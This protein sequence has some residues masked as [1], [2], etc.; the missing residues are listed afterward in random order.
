MRKPL[1]S[2]VLLFTLTAPLAAQ[3]PPE[4]CGV[5]VPMP[6]PYVFI[7]L[8]TSGSMNYGTNGSAAQLHV[9]LQGDD[10]ASK[11][12]MV[13]QALANVL[14]GIDGVRFGFATYPNHDTLRVR[15]KHWL[16]QATGNGPWLLGWGHWPAAGAQEVFGAAWACDQGTGDHEIGCYASTPADLPDAWE[17]T[18]VRRL[19]KGGDLL[20]QGATVY[21]RNSTTVFRVQYAP[22]P[23]GSLGGSIQ[24]DVTAHRCLDSTCTNVSLLGTQTVTWEPVGEFLAWDAAGTPSRTQPY[25][26]FPAATTDVLTNNACNGWEPNTDSTPNDL[27]SYGGFTY[28]LK[29]PT[30]ASDPRGPYFAFGD[31]I[32]FDWTDDHKDDV[33]AR[34]APNLA[35]DPLAV[36]DVRTSAYLQDHPLPGEPALRL[37]D[38]AARPLFAFGPSPLAYALRQFR[39]WY[40][41]CDGSGCSGLPL[42]GWADVAVDL[43]PD[44]ECRR[45]Y[46]LLI[47]DNGADECPAVNA[48]V[49]PAWLNA[50]EGVKSFTLGVGTTATGV[51]KCVAVNG[52]GEMYLGNNQ[53][54]IEQSLLNFFAEVTQP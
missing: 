24:T 25:T 46:L 38:E 22:V 54:D 27:Y 20:T 8:D 47:T 16:Y 45:V 23:G 26:F 40:A 53:Q 39:A 2:A 29:Q 12:F 15:N 37:E 11:W 49:Q 43:D 17:A 14:P 35:A 30:D 10:P 6:D 19:A 1:L 50:Y 13:K 42:T 36:P 41:G 34:I 7:L 3:S 18:R 48:C 31:M 5:T 51:G 32:P 9:P 21:L 44:W 4:W 33:L 28:G 52:K